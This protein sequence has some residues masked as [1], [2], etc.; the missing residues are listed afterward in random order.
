MKGGV[1]VVVEAE[2]EASHEHMV[3]G[4]WREREEGERGQ[5]AW[6]VRSSPGKPYT[7]DH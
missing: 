6:E 3:V 1:E 2:V 4:E 5:R 7:T